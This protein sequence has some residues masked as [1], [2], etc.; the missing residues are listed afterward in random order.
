MTYKVLFDGNGGPV[1]R[2]V[3]VGDF[4]RFDAHNAA[5][6]KANAER[7]AMAKECE[8]VGR[9]LFEASEE[10]DAM[11]AQLEAARGAYRDLVGAI[12]D[13]DETD[14][15][16]DEIIDQ[17]WG[18]VFSVMQ[19]GWASI[20]AT[21]AQCLANVRAEAGRAGY[22]AGVNDRACDYMD[23]QQVQAGADAHAEEVRAGGAA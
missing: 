5:L 6:V 11:A 12:N 8:H 14:S 15:D 13:L 22:I 23:P 2:I 17:K 3:G 1:I 7:D 19:S 10:R 4:V 18:E 20:N 16:S 21:P 9:H